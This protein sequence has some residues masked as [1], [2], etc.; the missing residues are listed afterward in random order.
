VRWLKRLLLAA[1]SLLLLDG[2]RQ[3]SARTAALP[4]VSSGQT[5]GLVRISFSG[6]DFRAR[7]AGLGNSGP[8]LILLHGFP[9]ISAKQTRRG[10]RA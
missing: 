2:D 4:L 3:H 1:G 5:D 10:D 7:V 8:G 6:M 9:E